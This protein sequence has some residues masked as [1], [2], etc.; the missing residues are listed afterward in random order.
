MIIFSWF[1]LFTDETSR[2]GEVAL[3][4]DVVVRSSLSGAGRFDQVDTGASQFVDRRF[5]AHGNVDTRLRFCNGAL[6]VGRQ[7]RVQVGH[8]GSQLTQ[9]IHIT[10]SR[11]GN[12]VFKKRIKRKLIHHH[13]LLIV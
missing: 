10:R 12:L 11:F 2:V 7:L 5:D 3:G 6:R 1:Y 13:Y 4:E 8:R 9:L